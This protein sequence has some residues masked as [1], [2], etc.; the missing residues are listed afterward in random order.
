MADDEIVRLA[1][2]AFDG[3]DVEALCNR[4]RQLE[5]HAA[6]RND[7]LNMNGKQAQRIA[8]LEALLNG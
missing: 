1:R 3:T 8:Q 6:E 7:A 4:I 5:R 2:L